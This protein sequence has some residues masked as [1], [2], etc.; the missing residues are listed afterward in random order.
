MRP[1][2]VVGAPDLHCED[3]ATKAALWK[4]EARARTWHALLL[5]ATAKSQADALLAPSALA[6]RAER[7]A[8]QLALHAKYKYKASQHNTK[9]S[10]NQKLMTAVPKLVCMQISALNPL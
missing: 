1:R 5:E 4:L 8:L 10:R 7:P 3:P 9:G 6:Q 2:I